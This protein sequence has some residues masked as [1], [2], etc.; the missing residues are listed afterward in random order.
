MYYTMSSTSGGIPYS[1]CADLGT[2]KN[3]GARQRIITFLHKVLKE[4]RELQM[5]N[6]ILKDENIGNDLLL[7]DMQEKLEN[8]EKKVD[9][10]KKLVSDIIARGHKDQKEIKLLNTRINALKRKIAEKE[11]QIALQSYS[12]EPN[13]EVDDN[14]PL[15]IDDILTS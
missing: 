6:A 5:N 14:E 15:S 2:V 3:I 9:E 8:A 7:E 12:E 1:I 13:E 11:A 4:N 10:Y